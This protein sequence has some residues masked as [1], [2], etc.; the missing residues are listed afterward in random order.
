MG[1]LLRAVSSAIFGLAILSA[2]ASAQDKYPSKPIKIIVPFAPGGGT[3]TVARLV[4]SGMEKPLGQK[5]I[6]E[7][8]PGAGTN[9]GAQAVA[10]AEPDGY[11]LMVT[12]DQTLNMNP[13][14]YKSLPF[15][16]LKDFAPISM[17][18]TGPRLYVASPQGPA[19]SLKELVDYMKA[20]PEKVNYGSGAVASNVVGADLMQATGTKMVF[21][22]FNGGAP[23]LTALLSN[24]IQFVIADI[25]TLGPSVNAGKLLGLA[26]SGKRRSPSVPSVPTLAEIGYGNLENEG[27]WGLWAPAGT[28]P[29]IIQMLNK[30]VKESLAD[31]T[32][33]ERIVA[34]G[35]EPNWTTPEALNEEVKSSSVRWG[36]VIKAAGMEKSL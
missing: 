5:V 23:A 29:Q 35:N 16:P 24:E 9:I 1:Q 32:V 7:N 3:D 28:P 10:R 12:V 17:L 26:V 25:G 15:D 18:A 8:R 4:A 21:I 2:P 20:N 27:W 11:T 22:S 31:K 30:A 14:L 36:K 19:K 6:I 13:F 33:N 34:T